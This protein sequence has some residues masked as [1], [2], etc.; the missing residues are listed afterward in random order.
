MGVGDA[1]RSAWYEADDAAGLVRD[2][3]AEL[4]RA[5]AR[6]TGFEA[7]AF[8]EPRTA[9]ALRPLEDRGWR[10]FHDRR[11]P[12]STRAN[13]D[14]LVIGPPGVMVVDT[15]HGAGPVEVRNGR[16]R[17]CEEDRH[18]AVEDLLRLVASTEELLL[19][20]GTGADGRPAGLSPVHVV[21]VLAFTSFSSA[22]RADT[23][24]GRVRLTAVR[25]LPALLAAQ[26]TVLSADEIVHLADYLAE[27]SATAG[28][29]WPR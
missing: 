6:Q 3:E 17:A 15:K 1:G 4:R 5:Y 29:A 26:P 27:Q 12:G 20:L 25:Q 11:W 28:W 2:P 24:V 14:H 10:V 23:R 19:D 21:P 7:A 8:S 16:L 18:D 9:L 13:V 22:R